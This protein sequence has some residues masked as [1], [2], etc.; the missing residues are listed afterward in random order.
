MWHKLDRSFA[1]PRA[2]VCLRLSSPAWCSGAR[3]AALTHLALKALE[4]GLTEDAYLAE[5]AG[6]HY[7]TA[8]E[9]MT[10]ALDRVAWGSA[11]LEALGGRSCGRC[12]ERA[13]VELG[14]SRSSS[15]RRAGAA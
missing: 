1:L 9:G 8:P 15:R 5:V 10:G 3:Q 2:N 14:V 11:F 7:S 4:D 6:L 13:R 12:P